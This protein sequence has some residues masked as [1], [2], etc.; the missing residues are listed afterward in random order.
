[1]HDVAAGFGIRLEETDAGCC[2]HPSRGAVASRFHTEQTVNTACPAC[3]ASLQ[4]S[5]MATASLWDTLTEHARRRGTAMQA[6]EPRFVPYVGCL[7]QRGPALASLA[8]AAE[9][10]HVEM[11]TTYP[12]LHSGCCGALGGT[13]RGATKASA[14]LLE[15]AAAQDAPLVS[16]CSLCCDNLRSAARGLKRDVSIHFWPEFFRAAPTACEEQNDD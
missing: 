9:L 7:S 11:K 4:K 16:P 8:T 5:G 2:G 10:A 14:M 15:F 13:Y 1:V 6:A 3:D 12:S